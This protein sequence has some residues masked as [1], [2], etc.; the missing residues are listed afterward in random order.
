MKLVDWG[1]SRIKVSGESLLYLSFWL[2]FVPACLYVLF[3][4]LRMDLVEPPPVAKAER[5]IEPVNGYVF[6]KEGFERLAQVTPDFSAAHWKEL[7]LPDVKH[8]PA[9]ASVAS[10]APM[11]RVWFRLRYT[12][13]A[14][15]KPGESIV[16]YGTRIMGGAWSVWVDGRL[17]AHDLEDWRMQ[18]NKPMYVKLPYQNVQPGRAIEIA[19]A[20]PFR[21]AQ[22]YA[23]GSLF[24]GPADALKPLYDA[25]V[26]WQESL[27]RA[28]ILVA[29]LLGGISFFFWLARRSET[30]H[31]LLS[32]T[33]AAWFICNLQYFTDF[34]SDTTASRW[35]GAIVDASVSWL[36]ILLYLFAFRFDG[37]RFPR[38]E[39]ALVAYAISMTLITLPIWN[40]EMNA[41]VL[42]HD[43]NLAVGASATLFISWMAVRSGP[44]LRLI[45]LSLWSL[46]ILGA[47]DVLLLTSQHA[48][49]S[50][51]LFPYSTFTIFGAFLFSIQ[52][53]YLLAMTEIEQ[54]NV[55]LDQ[56]LRAREAELEIKHQQL[57]LVEQRQSLLQE[58][59]RLMQDMHDGIGS[60]LMSSLALA[61]HGRL[62]PERMST[63]LRECVDELKLSIDSLEPIG[64][65]LVTLLAA[66]RFRLGQ[67]LEAAGIAI[68]WL[69]EDLPPLPWLEPP[70]ALQVLRILQETL[71][72][73][74]KHAHATEVQISARA[75]NDGITVCIADNGIGFSAETVRGGRGLK[76]MRERA[77]SL[78]ARL[79]VQGQPG[80]GTLMELRLQ[81]IPEYTAKSPIDLAAE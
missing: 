67:R 64:Y 70:Q 49:D 72:N 5:W 23:V 36:F 27:P 80:R 74:L 15:L 3:L 73:V 50:M 68:A 18:W 66:L 22:G 30:P 21:E 37:R 33:A 78:G 28:S 1:F 56:L 32:L 6:D 59:Q 31:V 10:D 57:R 69:M 12:P 55:S 43:F 41:L 47:H 60:A 16:L 63:V 17:H 48:P 8:L 40:W 26:F 65:D 35:F 13:P 54:H 51:H 75:T 45:A 79:R 76:N 81:V 20:V 29:L 58:R 52:R 7:P 71:T 14:S 44:E 25:R 53:R 19:L 34:S 9:A 61:E 39:F 42:Q 11:A 62:P 4:Y 24:L 46:I 38:I 2:I 77:S